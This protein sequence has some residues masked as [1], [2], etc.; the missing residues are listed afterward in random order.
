MGKSVYGGSGLWLVV[1]RIYVVHRVL[2]GLEML[3][4]TQSDI[5]ALERLQRAIMRKVKSLPSNTATAAV[6]CLLGVRSLNS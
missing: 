3:S 5:Q 6:T 2:Y 1:L 4:C